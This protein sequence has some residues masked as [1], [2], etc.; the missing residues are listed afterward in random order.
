MD[1]P[2]GALDATFE[3]VK[4]IEQSEI[5]IIGYVH[6]RGATAWSAGTVILISTHL[7]AMTPTTV[8]GSA[9]PVALSPLGGAQPINDTKVINALTTFVEERARSHN[10]NQTAAVAF[11][12]ENLNVNAEKAK[13]IGV[14]E[15]IAATPKELLTAVDGR[16][17]S[18]ADGPVTL[19]TA[20]A[21]LVTW[22][23]S[24]RIT[25]LTVLSNPTLAFI[26]LTIGI[27]GL[28]FGFSAP[29]HGGEV[30]GAVALILGLI[31]LGI[32]GVN[33]GGFLLIGVGA[34]LM[35]VDMLTQGTGFMAVGGIA[36]TALGGI[37]LFQGIPFVINPGELTSLLSVL[38]GGPVVIGAFFMFAGFKILKTR[39]KPPFLG[40]LGG[41][42]AE[43]LDDFSAQGIGYVMF[44]GEQWRA[45][46]SRALQKGETVRIIEKD[47]PVLVVESQNTK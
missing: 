19:D 1:T 29:G 22:S 10:R 15:V 43:A 42:S 24:L 18:L 2:G 16:T 13:E 17:V 6:P 44:Q 33:I 35:I 7:A 32:T 14:I 3:I 39:R 23:P 25:V 31:G 27:F 47:G 5:P 20:D 12:T 40:R 45:R 9:Q 46:S 30:V 4:K 28:I 21:Q 8:I 37:L 36:L 11:I 41:E 38:I 26:F 34:I